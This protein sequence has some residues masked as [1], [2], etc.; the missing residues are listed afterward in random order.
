MRLI[1]RCRSHHFALLFTAGM[2]VSIIA[3]GGAQ[4]YTPLSASVRTVLQQSIADQAAP[5]LSF[6]T[7]QE[8]QAWLIEMSRRLAPSMPDAKMRED[9]LTTVHYEATRAGLDPQMVLGLIE[10]ES[11]FHKYA[12]SPAGAR[13]YMQVMP[14]WVKQIGDKAQ[15]LFHLRTNLRFGCT[16]LRYYLDQERG[17]L[18]RALGRYNGSV[19]R[20]EYPDRV[21]A[22]WHQHWALPR[23]FAAPP[24]A[25]S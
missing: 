22:A 18:F 9:F 19:G 12:I 10:V 17:N 16:I 14:F 8:G 5:R 3:Q 21:R 7:E 1:R 23:A 2:L 25:H 13:G 11:H 20:A 15:N 4:Q 6:A 24:V